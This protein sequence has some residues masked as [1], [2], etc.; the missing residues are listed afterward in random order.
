MY[1]F[2]YTLSDLPAFFI[3]TPFSVTRKSALKKVQAA[4]WH[5]CL[6]QIQGL[7]Q[8]IDCWQHRADH[9]ATEQ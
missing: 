9:S 4:A 2:M 3:Q 5:Y 7:S 8:I 1:I 6:V